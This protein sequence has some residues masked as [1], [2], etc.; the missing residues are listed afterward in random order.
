MVSGKSKLFASLKVI[1]VL[2][3]LYYYIG[4]IVLGFIMKKP[5]SS[6]YA[7]A[8]VMLVFLG[9]LTVST[10]MIYIVSPGYIPQDFQLATIPEENKYRSSNY[11]SETDLTEARITECSSCS[12]KSPPKTSHCY[13]CKKC[14]QYRFSHLH[15][16]CKCIGL[17]NIKFYFIL[18]MS[19]LIG[20]VT[21]IGLDYMIMRD[22]KTPFYDLNLPFMLMLS[23]IYS[24]R[25][26]YEAGDLLIFMA[27]REMPP[28]RTEYSVFRTDSWYENYKFLLGSVFLFWFIPF[29]IMRKKD[30]AVPL[31]L[32][33]TYGTTIKIKHKYVCN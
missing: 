10:I 27:N 24:L 4:T 25:F 1:D 9:L 30:M 22:T 7:A 12:V 11:I 32:R 6:V 33:T 15:L 13:E 19:C 2:V 16:F 23:A 5:T 14:V 26:I 29:K 28:V 18:M 8:I 31:R 21:C 3:F 20:S 17:Y